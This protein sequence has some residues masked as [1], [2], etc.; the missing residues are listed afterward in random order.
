MLFCASRCVHGGGGGG[1]E[2]DA[3][4]WMAAAPR[5]VGAARGGVLGGHGEVVVFS[6]A[7][8]EWPG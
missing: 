1:K 3:P 7:V 2:G 5:C 4:S 8:E 6:S